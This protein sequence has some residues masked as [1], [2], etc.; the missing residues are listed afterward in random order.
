MVRQIGS[1]FL[2]IDC[3]DHWLSIIFSLLLVVPL[4]RVVISFYK[5]SCHMFN[6]GWRHGSPG[7]GLRRHEIDMCMDLAWGIWH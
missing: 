1:S 7:G 6:F 4:S 2:E 3:L 5:F